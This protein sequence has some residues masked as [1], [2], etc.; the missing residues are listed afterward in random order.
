[1]RVLLVRAGALGDLLLLRPLIAALRAASHSVGLIAPASPA[2]PLVREVD[3][4]F[5]W[6][7]PELAALLA[8]DSIGALGQLLARSDAVVAFTRS[9]SLSRTLS[10]ATAVP[11]RVQ[12]PAP[13]RGRHAADWLRDAVRDWVGAGSAPVASLQPSPDEQAAADAALGRLPDG[14]LALHPGSGSPAKNW[15]RERFRRLAERLSPRCP[16]LLVRGEADASACAPLAELPGAVLATQLPLRVLGAALHR[17]GLFIGNDSGVSHLAAAYGAPTLALFG[18]TDPRSWRPLGA[19]VEAIRAPGGALQG[20]EVED[21]LA[22][23]RG[24]LARSG[25]ALPSG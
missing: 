21:V 23:A 10:A 1:V 9:D 19:H 20:L 11:V 25:R 18:T 16:F 3:E 22:A 4:L 14:F 12:D 17:S 13:P 7:R 8:G 2:A 15:P 5:P 24:L 6:E